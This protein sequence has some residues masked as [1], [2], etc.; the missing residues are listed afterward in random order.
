[1]ERLQ[2]TI[3]ELN[4]KLKNE[5]KTPEEL[6]EEFEQFY[7][8]IKDIATHPVVLRM[9]LYPHHGRDELLSALSPRFLL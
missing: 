1:M 2:Q 8:C 3:T 5:N 6:D 7:E 4:D 9:K